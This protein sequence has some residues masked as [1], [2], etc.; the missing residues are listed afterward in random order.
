M[1]CVRQQYLLTWNSIQ[2]DL[3]KSIVSGSEPCLGLFINNS[4][5]RDLIWFFELNLFSAGHS[6]NCWSLKKTWTSVFIKLLHFLFVCVFLRYVSQ[7]THVKKRPTAVTNM[8]NVYTS[9]TL[10][11]QCTNVSVALATLEMA[12][13][14]ERT[15]TW[16]D[17]PIR[18]WSAVPTVHTTAKRYF[19]WLVWKLPSMLWHETQL[20]NL[21]NFL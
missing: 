11:T 2:K 7:K 21:V 3:I 16:M 14:V 20:M 6:S 19:E 12:F 15:Q 5:Y 8:L 13:Y 9:A 18:T 10:V 17:G 4:D 1:C